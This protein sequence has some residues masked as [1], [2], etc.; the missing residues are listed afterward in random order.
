MQ[1]MN[2]QTTVTVFSYLFVLIQACNVTQII[3]IIMYIIFA[4]IF[5]YCILLLFECRWGR[6]GG[7]GE[8]GTMQEKLNQFSEKEKYFVFAQ[9]KGCNL[10]LSIL[11]FLSLKSCI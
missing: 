7:G 11:E 10:L 8:R 3:A 2:D 1:L 5:L 6:G 4:H 9:R